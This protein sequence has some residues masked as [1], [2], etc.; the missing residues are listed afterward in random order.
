[1]ITVWFCWER[2]K[3]KTSQVLKL[4]KEKSCFTSIENNHLFCW[5]S[6]N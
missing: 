2:L 4:K 1:M 6:L 5:E 3:I